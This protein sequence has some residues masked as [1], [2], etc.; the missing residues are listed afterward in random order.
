MPPWPELLLNIPAPSSHHRTPASSATCCACGC[1]RPRSGR[2]RLCTGEEGIN[3]WGWH[4][5]LH[6][7]QFCCL[8]DGQPESIS[9]SCPTTHNPAQT[10]P[11]PALLVVDT[12]EIMGGGLEAGRRGGIIPEG[13]PYVPLTPTS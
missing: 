7:T 8:L 4:C 12:R 13:R 3:S 5:S 11:H 2:C 10:H 1:R 6:L 9:S